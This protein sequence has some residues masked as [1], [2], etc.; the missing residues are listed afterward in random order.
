M[1]LLFVSLAAFA[2]GGVLAAVLSSRPVAASAAGA[3]GAVIGC[4]AGAIFAVRALSG[5]VSS[6]AS[7]TLAW[8]VPSGGIV[9]M[10][11]PLSGF[12]MLPLFVL[13]GLAAVYGREYLMPYRKHH[14]LGVPW[15][16]YNALLASMALVLTARHAMLFLV[17]WE[18]M[19]LASYV[20]VVFEYDLDDVR[21]AGWVYLIAAHVGMALLIAMFLLLG[22]STGTLVLDGSGAVPDASRR[23]WILLL[24]LAGF[25]VKA[26]IVPLHVWLPEAH[27][28]AP[29][30]VSALMS[31]VLTKMGV[32]GIVRVV[33]LT[34]PAPAWWG[35]T[36][37][38]VGLAGG[39]FGIAM[40]AYQR[41]I[42]R[43]LAYSTIENVGLVLL[44]LGLGFW[45]HATG[46]PDIGTLGLLGGL[47]HAW[48][49]TMMK[50]LLFLG[51]GTI[52]H[53]TGTRDIE[54][55]GGL[56]QR[57]P[58]GGTLFVLG[59]VAIAGLPPLNG[60]A[61][62]WLLYRSLLGGAASS[63]VGAAVTFMLGVG[64]V[65][66]IGALAALCFVRLCA[67]SLLGQPRS[68]KASLA[69]EA[70]MG[71]LVPMALLAVGCVFAGARPEIVVRAITTVAR[72]I[73]PLEPS[74]AQ[75]IAASLAPVGNVAL[76][77]WSGALFVALWSYRAA[78]RR[79]ADD[80]ATWGCGYAAPTA[81][82]QYTGRS[83]AQLLD[84]ML[85]GFM[86]ARVAIVRPSGQFPTGGS[87]EARID[88][89]VTRGV[90]EPAL[91]RAGERFAA[92]RIMQQ[93]ALHLYLLYVVVAVVLGLGWV[94]LEGWIA[95]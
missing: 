30:H 35:R 55:L 38:V 68:E 67:T 36:L 90:Y 58:I 76:A 64:A 7:A 22:S 82:M 8:H 44:G 85:P 4:I 2:L 74:A 45:G 25:G 40:A 3:G 42:K 33:M 19:S 28:A 48:N 81:R 93:G 24:A 60:F 84:G 77:L 73:V 65:S 16:A 63:T 32:Y 71:M 79:K 5:G 37:I 80:D 26:G 10:S 69:H 57:M 46:H 92:I 9:V 31:G 95:R 52:V 53:A 75:G 6:H 11:D 49:H 70:G 88:D 20:L 14:S 86:R 43:A 18:V 83:F 39:V 94:S 61:S 15:A 23:A 78:R 54:R 91:E 56:M 50:G 51:A 27:A 29:S 87:L 17:S 1:T 89:P 21:R 66:A 62:E 59:S 72:T 13:G 34:G 47:L 41:D 12:F